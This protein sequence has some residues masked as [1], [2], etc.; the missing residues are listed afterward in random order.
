VNASDGEGII[1]DDVSVLLGKHSLQAGGFY[2]FGIK[3]QIT[4]N[5]PWGN[6]SFGGTYTGSGAADYLLG[7][8]SGYTQDSNKPHYTAHYRT[9]EF[10]LQDDWKA[11]QRLTINAG[12]R[13]FYYS[14]D[15]LSGPNSATSSFEPS[16]FNPTVAAAVLPSGIYATNA[17]GVPITS[18]GS[19]ANLDNGLVFNTTPGVPRGFYHNNTIYPAPRV[20][21]AYALTSDNRTSIHGGYGMGY[22]RVPFRIADALTSN[23]P[24]VANVDFTSGTIENPT[25]GV[26]KASVPTPQGLV[27]VNTNFRASQ[28]QN[29]S[30]IVERELFPNAIFQVGYA[31]SVGRHLRIDTDQNQVKPTSTPYSLSC[32]A[33]GQTPSARYDFDPCL[34]TNAVSSA[35]LRPYQG[36]SSI[37]EYVFVGNDNYNSLQSQFR[38]K[39]KSW[40][41]TLN[42]TYGKAMG[43]ANGGSNYRTSYSTDQNSYCLTCEYGPRNFDRTHIFSGNVIYALPFA[44]T[45]TG[46]KGELFGGWS[47]SGIALLESGFAL[48]PSLSAPNT[49]LASRPNLVGPLH[50][51]SNR[52]QIFNASAYTVPAYG[53]FG[54]ASVGSIRG[55]KQIGFNTAIY[56]TFPIHDRINFQFR[57][58][59]FNVANHPTFNGVNTGIGPNDPDP[60]VVNSPADPRI[61]ELVGRISF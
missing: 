52:N 33:P 12:V 21:F 15:W 42:Y 37:N 30:L 53:F 22:T 55:P 7:L 59:A 1:S 44:N 51:S 32:L 23:P 61:M 34:N 28:I 29:F 47:V 9:T 14:P 25:S 10:Y 8:H 19:V 17:S 57:A 11:T 36:I 49:S 5:E 40:Q 46:L 2:I 45:A 24:G 26:E 39:R 3:N 16:Q 48:T 38:L 18:S 31:G 43:D 41:T 6:M 54:D 27:E 56:K 58:E 60:G 4:T 35:Y 50:I 13:F 20:G